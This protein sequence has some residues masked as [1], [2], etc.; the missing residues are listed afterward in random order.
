MKNDD[1]MYTSVL[2]KYEA[3]IDKTILALYLDG[4]QKMVFLIEQGNIIIY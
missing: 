2:S 4:T 1:E 3:Y